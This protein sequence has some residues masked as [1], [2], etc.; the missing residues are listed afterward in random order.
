MRWIALVALLG[1][2]FVYDGVAERSELSLDGTWQIAF[3]EDNQSRAETWY[4]PA[5]FAKLESVESID[6]P[7]CWETIRQDYE[8]VAVYGRSFTVPSEWKG[9]AIRLQFDAVNFRADVWLNGHAIGQHEGGYGPFEFQIDDLMDWQG[10]NFL[11]VRVLGPIIEENKTIDGLGRN[12]APHWRGAITGGIWQS[13]RLIASGSVMIDDLFVIP[14]LDQD[15]ARVELSLENSGLLICEEQ[16]IVEVEDEATGEVVA[17]EER[18]IR[19][20]PGV[21]VSEWILS[22]PD[23]KRWSPDAPNLYRVRAM[24]VEQDQQAHRFGMREL[25]IQDNEFILNGE[26]VYIKAAFFEG[27]YPTKLAL[28]DSREMAIQEI[29]LA[30]EAGFNMIRPWRKPPPP[31]WLDLCDEMGMMVVG[32]LPIECMKL[33][34]TVTPE[35]PRR[36]EN[37]VRSAILRDRNRACIVQWEM[38]NEIWRVEL[39]RLKHR[40][41]MVARELDPSRLVLDESGGFADGAN[42]YL[43][44]EVE[45]ITFNDVHIYCG[46]PI[47]DLTYAQFL[48]LGMTPDEMEH[49]G[50]AAAELENKHTRPGKMTLVSEIGYGSIPNLTTNNALFREKGNPLTP[51]YRYHQMLEE[52]TLKVLRES[53]LDELYPTLEDF[54]LE[55]QSLHAAANKRIIEAVRSN[56]KVRGYCVHALTGGDWVLGAGLLDLWRNKKRSYDATKAANADQYLALRV[57]PRNIYSHQGGRVLVTGINDQ[58][59]IEDGRLEVEIFNHRGSRVKRWNIDADLLHGVSALFS[60]A[61]QTEKWSGRYKAVVCFRS[62]DNRILS[63]NSFQFNVFDSKDLKVPKGAIAVIDPEKLLTPFLEK[64]QIPYEVFSAKTALSTPVFVSSAKKKLP[65]FSQLEKFVKA[66]GKA[67]YL[68]TFFQ[69]GRAY[70]STRLPPKGVLPFRIGKEHA[71]GLWVGV[72]H[73]VRD[74]PI[75]DG[76]EVNQM[77]GDLYENIWSPFTM[78]DV[79]GEPIVSSVTYGFYG[80]DKHE[81]QS[82][83]GPEPAFHGMD[84]GSFLMVKEAIF[85]SALRITPY[86]GE[87]PVADKVL[88]NLIRWA[89]R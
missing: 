64:H 10:T 36:I 45:P 50:Y 87:D 24:V 75:F 46:Y 40:M 59:S 32:G 19:L 71:L 5:S 7:S 20:K 29:R 22:I 80:G 48:A 38:F 89:I 49:L 60:E 8:G 41:S 67:V 33:W 6:V 3:D 39:K 23:A 72:S 31:M 70:W 54:C 21:D 30:K 25:T 69:T 53:G 28:P 47:N 26:P 79:A 42:I 66:G 15:V 68:E 4:L 84:M 35:M 11:S 62:S 17:R 16:V 78:V 77:M 12:D 1:G 34:P 18:T 83:R 82:Y 74:H 88:F 56:P 57:M 44:Y 52:T 86:L 73:V 55:Q 27:L 14:V 85:L 65:E 37:E 81:Q 51:P 9:K 58:E 13:V 63:E 2:L 43:P 76:L 61:L